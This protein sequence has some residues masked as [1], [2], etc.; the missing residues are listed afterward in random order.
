MRLSTGPRG[1][2][3]VEFALV[4]LVFLMVV[5]GIM[6]FGYFY[7]GKVSATAAVRVAARYA[8]VHPIAWDNSANPSTNS[9]EGKLVLTAVPAVVINDDAHVTISYVRPA[10]GAGTVCGH[11]SA[12]SNAFVGQTGSDNISNCPIGGNLIRIQVTYIYKW[13][14]P[15]F[16][17]A[18]ST[19]TIAGQADEYIEG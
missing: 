3:T 14:T 12:S 10:A 6:D 13:I 8:A 18:F 4:F 7:S 9:I 19:V 2:A 15:M 16:K 5:F 17:A 1:Q 11:Y